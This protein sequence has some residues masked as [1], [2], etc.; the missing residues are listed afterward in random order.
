MKS[1]FFQPLIEF[2]IFLSIACINQLCVVA[3]TPAS[4]PAT[5][6]F[7]LTTYAGY[8][9][10]NPVADYFTITEKFYMLTKVEMYKDTDRTSGFTVYFNV[11]PSDAFTGWPELSHTFG[12]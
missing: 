11:I 4:L 3:Q 8:V 12:T 6:P 1:T 5:I 7:E 2:I 10:T 9:E